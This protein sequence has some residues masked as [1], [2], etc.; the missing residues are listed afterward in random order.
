MNKTLTIT[1]VCL[2][3][4]IAVGV[5]LLVQKPADGSG[6]AAPHYFLPAVDADGWR[7]VACDFKNPHDRSTMRELWTGR[8]QPCSLGQ[9]WTYPSP[10]GVLGMAR[11]PRFEVSLPL[12]GAA[13]LL[14]TAKAYPNPE[15][16]RPQTVSVLVN[17]RSFGPAEVLDDWTTVQ[18]QLPE[19]VLRD[20]AN[21][22]VTDF[23]DRA[24]PADSGRR[25][26]RKFSA[27]VR[28]VLVVKGA[29]ET[30]SPAGVKRWLGEATRQSQ[31][32]GVRFDAESGQYVV[33][34]SGT[35]VMPL[36]FTRDAARI[37]LRAEAKGGRRTPPRLQLRIR[38]LSSPDS[39]GPVGAEGS[40]ER[41]IL[42]A[43]ASALAGQT[44]IV[45]LDVQLAAKRQLV[46]V[47]SP[48]VAPARSSR[49]DGGSARDDGARPRS[50]DIILITLDAA[51]ADHV[52]CYGYQRATTPNLDRLA[53]RS[54]VF[55][56]AFA[57][58]PY[59]LCSVPTM[60]TGLSPLDH[61]ITNHGHRLSDAATTLAEYLS[62]VGY[63][64]ACISA[65]PNN[66]RTI[67]TDQG[68]DDFIETWRIEQRPG[69]RDPF[70]LSQMA[71]D[72]LAKNEAAAPIHLQLHYV[73]PHAPYDP[74]P[75]YDL[76]TDP[77][78]SG[79]FD[80][81]HTS[82]GALD[83][84]LWHYRPADLDHVVG[85]YDGNLRE[86]DAAVEQVLAALRARPRW[87]DTV[88]LVTS[89]HG[90]AFL[91]HGRTGH[92][93]TLYDEM[94]HVPFILRLPEDAAADVDT[95]R[96]ASL[97]DI[98]PTLLGLAGVMPEDGLAGIDLLAAG[99]LTRGR[100]LVSRTT[101]DPP[102]YA[103]RTSQ[104]KLILGGS[105]QGALFNLVRDPKERDDLALRV[106]PPFAGLGMLLTERLARPPRF[107]ALPEL[108]EL[109]EEDTEMLKALGYLQ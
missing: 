37:E 102:L 57:L 34:R 78:Y 85:L 19:G 52:S 56:E 41:M 108:A 94:L 23:S 15:R 43:D 42:G 107:E 17:G 5:C 30:L 75:E 84:Q 21:Q 68:Y 83:H 74:R 24:S 31:R 62:A 90:E 28:E 105:G 27:F 38:S 79:T 26:T 46:R 101:G 88:V 4:A 7:L 10:A 95:S 58:A 55:T 1:A 89:D 18:F 53:A 14:M 32:Q 109:P 25:D 13:T 76:F 40:K 86:A 50:P 93:S 73:P 63:R 72:W 59:T 77:G 71:V 66:S 6:Q 9:G 61:Q 44:A 35:L 8:L 97:A 39:V 92:N 80:G 100:R 81:Y 3:A 54:A 45:M 99:D 29:R 64:T 103:I 82:V 67:G 22:I 69:S 2:A 104:W 70:L 11:R 12:A 106:R 49:F 51:R 33:D 98:V 47:S 16:E 87:R 96:L 60:V 20:G 65:T 91:E 36:S 48:V